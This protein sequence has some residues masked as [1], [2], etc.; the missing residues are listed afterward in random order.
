MQKMVLVLSVALL[1]SGMAFAGSYATD[2]SYPNE[3]LGLE[4]VAWINDGTLSPA[5]RYGINDLAVIKMEI[6]SEDL[7]V[8]LLSDSA[9]LGG[10]VTLLIVNPSGPVPATQYP[11][12]DGSFSVTLAAATV[13]AIRDGNATGPIVG[14]QIAC[15]GSNNSVRFGAVRRVASGV[16]LPA[17][18]GFPDLYFPRATGFYFFLPFSGGDA[19]LANLAMIPIPAGTLGDIELKIVDNGDGTITATAGGAAVKE[20]CPIPEGTDGTGAINNAQYMIWQW[21]LLAGGNQAPLEIVLKSMDFSGSIILDGPVPYAPPGAV[22]A[23]EAGM[24]IATTLGLGLLAGAFA[25]G[26]GFVI[27]RKK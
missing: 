8:T 23:P 15:D 20:N 7:K 24:P 27:R 18:L 25:L 11:I 1:M 10:F 21:G 6:A 26:G 2:F 5:Y 12:A 22:V 4:T 17:Y 3:V 9:F 14:L 13:T 16:D 19:D